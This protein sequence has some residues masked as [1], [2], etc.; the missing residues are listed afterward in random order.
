MRKNNWYIIT[1]APHA[2]KTTLL[3]KLKERGYT[4]RPEAARVYIDREL[5][6]GKTLREI[7]KDEFAFQ[8]KILKI[9]IRNE[10][11]A[12]PEEVIFWDRGIP[13]SLA[14]YEMLETERDPFLQ[15]ALKE[16]HYKKVFLLSPLPYKKDYARTEN[17]DQQ[18]L[19]HRLLRKAYRKHPVVEL[20]SRSRERR[21]SAVLKNL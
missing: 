6:K 12:S 8:K 13:D 1:G 21:V 15:R 18:L 5:K 4:V 2:G 7:R 11:K 16:C 10:K 19:I 3:K 9:K 17:H 20:K 14:Y